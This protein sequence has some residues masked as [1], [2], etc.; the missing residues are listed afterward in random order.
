MTRMATTLWPTL[1]LVVCC[2]CAGPLPSASAPKNH[3]SARTTSASSPQALASKSRLA[4]IDF[5]AHG[6]SDNGCFVLLDLVSGEEQASDAVRCDLPRR[7]NSTFKIANALI[8]ADLGLLQ[9]ADAVMTY[10]AVRYPKQPGWFEGWDRDQPLREA[11][12][13]SAVPLFRKL[14]LDIGPERMATYLEKL[15]YGNRDMSG[16]PDA[17]WLQGG[18]R[19]SARQQ[20]AFVSRLVRDALPVSKHAQA[21]VREVLRREALKG[22]PHYGKTG[23]GRLESESEAEPETAPYVGWLVGFIELERGPVAYAM[24]LEASPFEALRDRRLATVDAVL[25][26]VVQKWH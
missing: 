14:A 24:W 6:L 1:A 23:T 19:I 10:D 13:I 17:F 21:L 4:P 2:A 3:P 22:R 8:G 16:G 20:V 15:D 11:M 5:S 12:R 25:A 26:E 7:P 18:L 9:N